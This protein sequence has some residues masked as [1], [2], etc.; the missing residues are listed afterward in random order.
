MKH[1]FLIAI[2]V[3]SMSYSQAQVQAQYQGPLTNMKGSD[4]KF[5]VV[6]SIDASAVQ[7]Q[8]QTSIRM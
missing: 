4:Y 6:K 8:N 3:C 2:A 7:N 5:T 1:F